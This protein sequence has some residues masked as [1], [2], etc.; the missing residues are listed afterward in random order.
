MKKSQRTAIRAWLE[1][2]NTS[3]LTREIL[4]H[5]QLLPN[6]R[7]KQVHSEWRRI[8]DVLGLR[9]PEMCTGADTAH[10][11]LSNVLRNGSIE[12]KT[13]A[14]A[15]LWSMAAKIESSLPLPFPGIVSPLIELMQV[16]FGRAVKN[17]ANKNIAPRFVNNIKT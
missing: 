1:Q 14:D 4:T 2:H 7:L 11:E 5:K 15:D 8:S 17:S 12:N 16:P 13:K 3:P 6:K 10:V 9:A